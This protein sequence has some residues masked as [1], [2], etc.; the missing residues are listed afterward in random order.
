MKKIITL[1]LLIFSLTIAGC[2][3]EPRQG[4]YEAKYFFDAAVMEVGDDHLLVEITDIGN[5]A[6]AA[7]TKAEVSIEAMA[8]GDYS[9]FSVGDFVR[10]LLASNVKADADS[11]KPLSVYK[12]DETGQPIDRAILSDY[13]P[14]VMIGGKLYQ[15][16]DKAASAAKDDRQDGQIASTCD[17]LP[18]ENNQSNFGTGYAWQYGEDNTVYIKLENGWFA[19]TAVPTI[20]VD[21]HDLSNSGA[22]ET[23][24]FVD[25]KNVAMATDIAKTNSCK[26]S[27]KN[28]SNIA[29]TVYLY[30]EQDA[31]T[32]IQEM[33]LDAGKTKAFSGLTSQ[34]C[35]QIGIYAE[36]EAEISLTVT[37]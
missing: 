31:T 20:P 23:A 36:T 37:D 15:D 21:C 34:R 24:V 6:F 4:D 10:V 1:L 18:T 2:S 14:L 3:Q 17:G 5:T 19:F 11:V 27:V 33:E 26:I 7:D 30:S 8:D 16:S 28:N 25:G 29:I 9:A 12:I 22:L 32:P 13:P 35:Y